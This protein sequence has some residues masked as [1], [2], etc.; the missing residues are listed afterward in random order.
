MEDYNIILIH[1]VCVYLFLC[2]CE[3]QFSET[4]R[5]RYP[6]KLIK[7]KR[8]ELQRLCCKNI[9]LRRYDSFKGNVELRQIELLMSAEKLQKQTTLF[10]SQITHVH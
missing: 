10:H 9:S 3:S 4:T 7:G 2:L 8:S 6:D 5:F 1:P